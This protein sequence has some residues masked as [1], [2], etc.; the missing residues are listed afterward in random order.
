MLLAYS[1]LIYCWTYN[2]CQNKSFLKANKTPLH[3]G[4]QCCWK[5]L[6]GLC[7]ADINFKTPSKKSQT[8]WDPPLQRHLFLNFLLFGVKIM[9]SLVYTLWFWFVSYK[10]QKDFKY[11]H[12]TWTFTESVTFTHSPSQGHSQ[13]KVELS[14]IPCWSRWCP[15]RHCPWGHRTAVDRPTEHLLWVSSLSCSPASLPA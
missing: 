8:N 3:L 6:A 5:I 4:E 10:V 7:L 1:G 9:C 13:T 14:H 15:F 2:N 11:L 12:I